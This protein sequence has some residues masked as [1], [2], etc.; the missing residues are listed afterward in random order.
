MKGDFFGGAPG[1]GV[2][3]E[4]GRLV[5]CFWMFCWGR[6]DFYLVG[7]G[8]EDGDVEIRDEVARFIYSIPLP[9][10]PHS[11][12]PPIPHPVISSLTSP[13]PLHPH[14]LKYPINTRPSSP[15]LFSATPNHSPP[16][17]VT[18]SLLTFFIPSLP[19]SYLRLLS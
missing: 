11:P 10:P 14:S 18:F 16:S 17:F 19:I 1:G 7:W 13:P 3:E 9:Q 5:G 6:E 15:T 4:G 8:C 2:R 12:C